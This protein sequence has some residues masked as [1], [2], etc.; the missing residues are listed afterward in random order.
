MEPNP[1]RLKARNIYMLATAIIALI[2][3]VL[4]IAI[5]IWNVSRTNQLTKKN[6]QS[7][8]FSEYT[9][10]YHDIILRM[11]LSMFLHSCQFTP[12]VRKY[13]TTYFN[14]CGE[15]FRLH[16]IEDILEDIWRN[17]GDGMRITTKPPIY[18]TGWKI[19]SS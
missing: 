4:T 19:L 15:E 14:L 1:E 17:W 11:P 16:K 18:H 10:R 6:H 12:E 9:G 3:S 5:T 7:I 13:L 2:I 8:I